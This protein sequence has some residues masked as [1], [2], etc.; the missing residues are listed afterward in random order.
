[1]DA[2]PNTWQNG[3]LCGLT[4]TGMNE[5]TRADNKQHPNSDSK[6]ARAGQALGTTALLLAVLALFAAGW[7]A[8]PLVACGI[9][10]IAYDLAIWRA[11][12]RIRLDDTTRAQAL[13]QGS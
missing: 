10:K 9:L 7:L 11:F 8:V 4:E 3:N 13:I 1:M 5:T 12:R 6:P 2:R